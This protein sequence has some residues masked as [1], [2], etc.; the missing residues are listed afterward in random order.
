MLQISGWVIASR[1]LH[2]RARVQA[3]V[4]KGSPRTLRKGSVVSERTHRSLTPE[5]NVSRSPF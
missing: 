4:H 5:Q 2:S 3:S 1:E